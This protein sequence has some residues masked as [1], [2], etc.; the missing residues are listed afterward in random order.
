M[1]VLAFILL[2]TFFEFSKIGT[3]FPCLGDSVYKVVD[4]LILCL[5]NRVAFW[6]IVLDWCKIFKTADDSLGGLR[7]IP[8][9]NGHRLIVL[10]GVS[11]ETE[12]NIKVVE[13]V[14]PGVEFVVQ[15]L[16]N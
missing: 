1:I 11:W 2:K 9:G 6:E 12:G 7:V 5:F 8:G 13:V 14:K 16:H 15:S 10:K 3:I 4:M